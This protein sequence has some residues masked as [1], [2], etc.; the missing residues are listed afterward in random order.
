MSNER[1]SAQLRAE[2]SKGKEFLTVP[3]LTEEDVQTIEAWEPGP[4]ISCSAR[5]NCLAVLAGRYEDEILRR[6]EG[7]AAAKLF[8]DDQIRELTQKKLRLQGLVDRAKTRGDLALARIRDLERA[9]QLRKQAD[10]IEAA[11][12]DED[13]KP[14]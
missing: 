13:G 9:V 7:A 11:Y 1:R 8:Y 12:L 2:Y 4:Y 5:R 3:Y 6:A 10:H 14:L